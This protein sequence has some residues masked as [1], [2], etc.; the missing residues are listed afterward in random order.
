M[1]EQG[2]LR[3]SD[4]GLSEDASTVAV[5]YREPHWPKNPE[6]DRQANRQRAGSGAV[7]LVNCYITNPR[8]R[9]V[10]VVEY[11]EPVQIHW[12]VE[13]NERV[14][15]EI[16][17][18][19]TI[20]NLK[21][22][23]LLSA[24]DKVQELLLDLQ[25]GQHALISM[26]Y[27]FPLKGDRY[28]FTTSIFQFPAGRKHLHESINFG[29]SALLDLVEYSCYFEVNWNRR[30]AHYGPVQLDGTISIIPITHT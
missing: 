18:A 9:P 4:L 16:S 11:N 1:R 14:N 24:T 7:K 27:S 15:A 29:E 10:N 23:E 30:W 19:I 12:I 25:A 5:G 22:V 8:G 6:F 13:A 17:L 3:K 26:P 20:K 21:G 28:Y 2:I